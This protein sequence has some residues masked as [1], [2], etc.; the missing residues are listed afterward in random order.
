MRSMFRLSNVLCPCLLRP[1]AQINS[2]VLPALR[3][4][5]SEE[6]TQVLLPIERIGAR[7]G[8]FW[9][10]Q[11]RIDR[12]V[13]GKGVLQHA[14]ATGRARYLL[15]ELVQPCR[16][17]FALQNERRAAHVLRERHGAQESN[18]T[19]YRG[20]RVQGALEAK[21]VDRLAHLRAGLL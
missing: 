13:S 18:D 3:S 11:H 14:F 10:R 9:N 17:D 12:F 15:L 5:M 7:S 20:K 16:L 19:Q 8:A 4:D 6:V 1:A 2:S 21:V